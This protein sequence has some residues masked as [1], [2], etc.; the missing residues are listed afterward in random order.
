MPDFSVEGSTKCLVGQIFEGRN[1]I[2]LLG[3]A[4]KIWGNLSKICIKIIKYLENIIEKIPE[5]CK[6]FRNFLILGR[7]YAKIRNIIWIGYNG[8]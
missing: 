4:Q 3:K 2:L 5:K 7:D 8:G 1:E 6:F